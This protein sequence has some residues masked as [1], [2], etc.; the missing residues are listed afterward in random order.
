MSRDLILLGFSLMTWGVGEAMFFIFQ[1][2]YLQQ[3]GANPVTI[4]AIF[5]ASGIAMSVAHIPAGHLADRIGRKPLLLAS[6]ILAMGSTWVMALAPSLP[7]F[8]IGMLLYN[9]TAFVSSPLS[10]YIT[11]ARGNLSVERA[12]TTVSALYNTGAILGPWLGGQVGERFGLRSIYLISGVT[13]ILSLVIL[14]FIKPQ[15]VDNQDPDEVRNGKFVD[16]RFITYLS[17]IF[18]AGFSMYLAQPLSS[19]YLQNQQ[20]LSLEAIGILGSISSLGI[21]VLNLGLGNLKAQLGYLLA[22]LS[23]ALFALILWR[24]T[25]FPW[26]CLGYFLVGGYRSSRSLATALIKNL[27][28]QS[29]MGLA[30]GITET[31]GASAIILAPPVAGFLYQINPSLMYIVGFILIVISILISARFIPRPGISVE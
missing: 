2:L 1:P 7:L 15:P 30:Y 23:V 21:V 12:L 8:V 4:G 10:S 26:F 29:R 17:I 9:L 3:L 16:R 6:W 5:G 13:F 18:L 24:G 14:L 11:A 31:V 19:N 25:S 22:Q 27:V 20:H 28:H